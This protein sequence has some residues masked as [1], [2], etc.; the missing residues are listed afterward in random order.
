MPKSGF[1]VL[2][3]RSNVG[4]S[5]LLNALVGSKVAITTPK[6]QTTRLPIQGIVTRPEGQIVFVDTPGIIKKKGDPLTKKLRESVLH[7]LKDVDIVAYVVDP[8]RE[9][10]DEEREAI[11]MTTNAEGKRILIIN[12]IDAP[13]KPFLDFYRDLSDQYDATVEVSALRGT[14]IE[15]L[16]QK[17]FEY[18]PEGERYYPEHQ[19]TNL[20]NR[21]WLA[22]LIREK[23]FLR[24]RQEVPYSTH[25]EITD[26][27]DRDNGM[28]YIAATV[29]T[30]DERYK[31]M[32]IGKNGRGIKEIGQSTRKELEGVLN[33][34]VFLDLTVEVDPHWVLRLQE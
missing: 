20:G 14:H 19:L 5:T 33:Q 4:K 16:I 26:L 12:K 22:E 32:I 25:V 11:R 21:S 30:T 27:Q 18:L 34:K 17:L 2:I 29:F 13:Q 28:K 23:L 6:P 7:A 10:G 15:T 9:I 1:A 31:R 24:L 8:T 3:G